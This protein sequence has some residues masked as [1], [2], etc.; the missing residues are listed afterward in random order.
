VVHAF[1]LLDNIDG[2]AAGVG[3]IAASGLAF[4]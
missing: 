1:N 3:A 4:S 2:L